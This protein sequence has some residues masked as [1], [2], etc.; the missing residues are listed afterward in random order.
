ML[1][2]DVWK[3]GFGTNRPGLIYLSRIRSL[4]LAVAIF[5]FANDD[6]RKGK[7]HAMESIK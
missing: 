1:S 7:G 2:Y 3:L 5:S 4:T 6:R